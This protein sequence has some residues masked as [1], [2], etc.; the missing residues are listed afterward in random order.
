MD[1]LFGLAAAGEEG[2]AVWTEEAVGA[3]VP[4]PSRLQHPL[5]LFLFPEARFC[6]D[7]DL[8][9]DWAPMHIPLPAASSNV[10]WIMQGLPV[11]QAPSEDLG[12]QGA[13]AL[14]LLSPPGIIQAICL[15][16]PKGSAWKSGALGSALNL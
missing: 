10:W 12:T 9:R 2:A 16:S 3:A 15:S 4:T 5:N 8:L 1:T 11:H 6:W 7:L 13:L 14:M